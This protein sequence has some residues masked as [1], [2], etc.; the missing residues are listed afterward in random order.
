MPKIVRS[1][2]PLTQLESYTIPS[3]DPEPIG[4]IGIPIR[5][6]VNTATAVS[7]IQTVFAGGPLP[8]EVC[9]VQGSILTAQRNELVYRM[10]GD[11]LLFIDDDMA[12]QP[13]QIQ[14][15]IETRDTHDLDIVGGLCFRRTE[16]HQPTLYMRQNPTTGPY[17]FLEDWPEN[18]IVEVDAT[19]MAFVLVHKRVF[20]GIVAYNENRP[21]WTMPS[22][23][24]RRA[25]PG[26]PPNFFR[27]EGWLG[28]DLRFCQE[29]K[30][31]GFRVWVDTGIEVKHLSEVA[32]GKRDFLME[33]AFRDPETVEARK[34][35][36]DAMGLPTVT[37]EQAREKL[38]W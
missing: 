14:K 29:A 30:E 36:N 32:I 26:N 3:L 31:A 1:D 10:R 21:G 33:L 16:P 35:Q 12:W 17:N 8:I 11:W 18:E 24:E 38:G 15:L 20:E 2:S 27:W 6:H 37:P 9:F 28:E 4:T 22:I 5:D 13:D 25:R 34:F 23:E 7:L 19:G